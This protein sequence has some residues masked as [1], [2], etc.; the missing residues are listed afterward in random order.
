M[1]PF[2]LLEQAKAHLKLDKLQRNH[3]TEISVKAAKA[4]KIIKIAY[5][6]IKICKSRQCLQTL[7]ALR[8]GNQQPSSEQ[9][10]V[11]RLRMLKIVSICGGASHADEDIV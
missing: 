2:E 4:E 7:S 8:M 3:E 1:H 9:E 11:Q 6:E 10:K 5:A